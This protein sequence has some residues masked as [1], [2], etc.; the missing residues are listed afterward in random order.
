MITL[1]IYVLEGKERGDQEKKNSI[2]IQS[3]EVE[4][5][6]LFTRHILANILRSHLKSQENQRLFHH[7]E[8][9]MKVLHIILCHEPGA[10]KVFKRYERA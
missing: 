1:N 7:S 4:R 2:N 6:D 9:Q 5:T 3:Y 8:D 10:Y